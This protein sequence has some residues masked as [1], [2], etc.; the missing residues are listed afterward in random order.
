MT[1]RQ[2]RQRDRFTLVGR[3]EI[4]AN[5]QDAPPHGAAA[6]QVTAPA[7]GSATNKP[8]GKARERAR[9]A[10]PRVFL[11]RLATCAGD[12]VPVEIV[13]AIGQ[14]IHGQPP[15]LILEICALTVHR[16]SLGR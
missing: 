16:F 7:T 9:L 14:R 2:L 11:S 1:A 4:P 15:L 13:D 10:C 5:D 8:R 6:C 12:R 3:V